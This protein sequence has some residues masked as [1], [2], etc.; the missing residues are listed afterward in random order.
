MLFLFTIVLGMHMLWGGAGYATI[1]PVFLYAKKRKQSMPM[2]NVAVDERF[3][4]LLRTAVAGRVAKWGE[5]QAWWREVIDPE[6]MMSGVNRRQTLRISPRAPFHQELWNTLYK[7]RKDVDERQLEDLLATVQTYARLRMWNYLVLD[8]RGQGIDAMSPNIMQKI[9]DIAVGETFAAFTAGWND[10]SIRR[11]LRHTMPDLARQWLWDLV[12]EPARWEHTA[13]PE[14][15]RMAAK[16]QRSLN[17][18]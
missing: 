18:G 12:E 14:A 1:N 11:W 17:Q 13:G 6:Q 3:M 9:V 8:P 2:P 15:V 5:N 4:M 7:H 10:E 16:I